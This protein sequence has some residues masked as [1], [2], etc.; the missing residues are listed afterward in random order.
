[1][2]GSAVSTPTN[3]E[4]AITYVRSGNVLTLMRYAG[5]TLSDNFSWA[6]TGFRRNGYSYDAGGN[7]SADGTKESALQSDGSGYVYLGS[8]RFTKNASGTLT[9]DSAPWDGGRIVAGSTAGAY[10]L[11]YFTTDHLGSIRVVTGGSGNVVFS[12]GYTPYGTGTN[13][14]GSA[15][16][17]FRFSGKE[18]QPQAGLLDFGARFYDPRSA[19]WLSPDPLAEKY[20]PVSPYAYC[21]NDPLDLVDPEGEDLIVKDIAI[22][23]L[24]RKSL[25]KTNARYIQ[26]D[27]NGMLNAELLEKAPNPSLNLTSLKRLASSPRAYYVSQQSEYSDGNGHVYSFSSNS[28]DGTTGVTLFP[29]ASIDSSPDNN[30]YAII[31]ASMN[32]F[33]KS[34]TLAHVLYGHAYLYELKQLGHPVDFNHQYVNNYRQRMGR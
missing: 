14:A 31:S 3:T 29:G 2:T 27:K 19:S 33:E 13:T 22:Q 6:Y 25:N 10:D 15:M 18:V 8:M 34:M 20:Y 1:M 21:A 32:D 4:T 28:F 17:E 7:V 24:I 16:N 23:D 30:I 12:S 9:F 11:Q 26:F 5:S